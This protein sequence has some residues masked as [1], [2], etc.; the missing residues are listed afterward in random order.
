MTKDHSLLMERLRRG[1]NRSDSDALTMKEA[2][3]EIER[4][5]AELA[6]APRVM[7]HEHWNA[8]HVDDELTHPSAQPGIP[9]EVP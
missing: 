5:R 3:D 8:P 6:A 7:I 4:L 1:I 2:A 9:W